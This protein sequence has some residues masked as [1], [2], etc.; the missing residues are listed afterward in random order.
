MFGDISQKI[1][2]TICIIEYAPDSLNNNNNNNLYMSNFAHISLPRCNRRKVLRSQEQAHSNSNL[3]QIWQ[4]FVILKQP[5]H[6][7]VT[8]FYNLTKLTMSNAEFYRGLPMLDILYLTVP[9]SSWFRAEFCEQQQQGQVK[10]LLPGP[11]VSR[12]RTSEQ[13]RNSHLN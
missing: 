12:P 8:V 6:I 1:V 10:W 4:L 11:R 13:P 2:K 3:M 9:E 5:V 7:S